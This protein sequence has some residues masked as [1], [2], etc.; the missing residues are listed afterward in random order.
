M[1]EEFNRNLEL[2]I[3]LQQAQFLASRY[4]AKTL[5][6]K[7]K[8]TDE[9]VKAYIAAHPEYSTEEKSAT[10]EQLLSRAKA[11]EDFAKLADEYSQDPGTKGKGGLYEGVTKG[12]MVPAFEQAALSLEPGKI[13]PTTLSK[14]LLV[15]T[16][17]S[18]KR[19]EQ[20]KIRADSRPKLTT[21][22][23]F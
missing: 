23:I 4:A 9:D 20:A 16:L 17:S 10:A 5:V 11:G 15:I 22:V 6:E 14:R 8:V 12:K 18:S 3:K 2:Q 19:K 7:V 1:G 21:L 13:A